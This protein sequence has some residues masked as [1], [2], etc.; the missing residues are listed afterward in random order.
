LR[1][2]KQKLA[3]LVAMAFV[4]VPVVADM[5]YIEGA[6]VTLNQVKGTMSFCALMPQSPPN[7]TAMRCIELPLKQVQA[8]AKDCIAIPVDNA[9][10]ADLVC[11]ESAI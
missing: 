5:V 8:I 11:D 3:I 2:Y 6:V 1:K 4:S 10:V 9:Q 7:G